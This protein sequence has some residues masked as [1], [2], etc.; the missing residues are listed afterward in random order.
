MK[1]SCATKQLSTLSMGLLG[2]PSLHGLLGDG[3][4]LFEL[5]ESDAESRVLWVF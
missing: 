4:G 1:A 3:V 5:V 2:L